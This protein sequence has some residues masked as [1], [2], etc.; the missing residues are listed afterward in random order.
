MET[1]L[2]SWEGRENAEEEDIFLHGKNC[3]LAHDMS[4]DKSLIPTTFRENYPIIAAD[5]TFI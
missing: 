3:N 2:R 4:L 1:A 5:E